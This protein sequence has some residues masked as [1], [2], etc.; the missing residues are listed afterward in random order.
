MSDAENDKDLRLLNEDPNG[1]VLR[2][3]KTIQIV[4]KQLI[5][6]GFFPADDLEDIVQS[7]TVALLEKMPVL[8]RQHTG[9]ALFRTYIS[10][11]IRNECLRLRR[12]RILVPPG[13]L[14]LVEETPSSDPAPDLQHA[15]RHDV[16]RLDLILRMF[17]R[18]RPRVIVSLKL[19][20]R[21]LLTDSDIEACFPN[22]DASSQ[23]ALRGMF[24]TNY[25]NWTAKRIYEEITPF[26]N[27]SEGRHNTP[28]ALR[29]WID[30]KVEE[31]IELLNR[32]PAGTAYDKETF[33]S[34]LEHFFSPI[35]TT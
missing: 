22:C 18:Q 7:V 5:A 24:G 15:L 30:D 4:A 9:Q 29:H 11:V 32:P 20:S 21:M 35:R 8:R 28:D 34:L 19:Y 31:I 6:R 23:G 27:A 25:D 10:V 16:D 3:Q 1:L 17:H 12:G 13:S 2:H 14:S 26:F 33:V